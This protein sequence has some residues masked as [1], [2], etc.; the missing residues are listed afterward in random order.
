MSKVSDL[1]GKVKW[2]K[3]EIVIRQRA[4]DTAKRAVEEIEQKLEQRE[5]ELSDAK[6]D[7]KREGTHTPEFEFNF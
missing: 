3:D 7:E 5:R 1:E 4:V 2:N 6:R